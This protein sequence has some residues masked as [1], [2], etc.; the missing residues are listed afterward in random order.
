M[1]PARRDLGIASVLVMESY[2]GR[3][4]P[5]LQEF[6]EAL[7]SLHY[8]VGSALLSCDRD[9]DRAAAALLDSWRG[10][11]PEFRAD[12]LLTF[13]WSSRD[14]TVDPST[15]TAASMYAVELHRYAHDFVGDAT[16]F[17]GARFPW[18]PL[19]GQAGSLASSLGF[20]RDDIEISL[21]VALLLATARTEDPIVAGSFWMPTGPN[22]NHPKH[23]DDPRILILRFP[24]PDEFFD[25]LKRNS[26]DIVLE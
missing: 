8:E 24:Q 7:T 18:M 20:D 17:H 14:G 9:R 10:A 11:E 19:P 22:P 5:G 2:F 6:V 12:L 16:E 21:A 13:A 1:N 4:D 26:G 15:D 25:S 23:P 3:T